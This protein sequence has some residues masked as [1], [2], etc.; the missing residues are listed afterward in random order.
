MG[1][2]ERY[3]SMARTNQ[4][5]K[6]LMKQLQNAELKG[7]TADEMKAQLSME[8]GE[9]MTKVVEQVNELRLDVGEIYY[10]SPAGVLYDQA[11]RHEKGTTIVS[12]GALAVKSAKRRDVLPW[13]SALSW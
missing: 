10:N 1:G 13:T 9:G 3:A 12:T 5:Q 2:G 6:S 7:W 11:L 4:L 8:V